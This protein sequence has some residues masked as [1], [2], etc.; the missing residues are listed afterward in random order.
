MEERG[1]IHQTNARTNTLL[2]LW[3]QNNKKQGR[4]ACL[5]SS[6]GVSGDG[7]T[8]GGMWGGVRGGHDDKGKNS[9]RSKFPFCQSCS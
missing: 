2:M 5:H 3:G 6:G 1:D 9:D 4:S 8:G 7:E